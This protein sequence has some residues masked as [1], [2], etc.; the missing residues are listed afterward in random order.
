MLQNR[1]AL[2]AGGGYETCS[3]RSEHEQRGRGA[4]SAQNVRN[5]F[6]TFGT[7]GTFGTFLDPGK[8]VPGQHRSQLMHIFAYL[9]SMVPRA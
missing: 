6:G 4:L 1:E 7:L 5:M 2:S 3:E 8:N 9:R